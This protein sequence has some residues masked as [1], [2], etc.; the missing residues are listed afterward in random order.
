LNFLNNW[1][2]LNQIFFPKESQMS[3]VSPELETSPRFWAALVWGLLLSGFLFP[4][5]PPIAAVI[6]A[7]VQ[8][9]RLQNTPFASHFAKAIWTFWISLILNAVFAGITFYF[10]QTTFAD[11]SNLDALQFGA[12]I[13]FVAMG[14]CIALIT[15][16][17][18]VRCIRG[19]VLSLDQAPYQTALGFF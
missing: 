10:A 16:W 13:P 18:F 2:S 17:Y 4:V 3:T 6:I 11:N 14:I 9:P 12:I 8:K 15:L 19:L 7:H 1:Y 5:L